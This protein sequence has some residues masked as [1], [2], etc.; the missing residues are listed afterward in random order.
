VALDVD[1]R[2]HESFVVSVGVIVGQVEIA[3]G[4][5]AL[6][7]HQIMGF[8]PGKIAAFEGENSGTGVVED[9]GDNKQRD[10]FFLEGPVGDSL[11]ISIQ[12]ELLFLVHGVESNHHE[13]K[14]SKEDGGAE[15]YETAEEI[16]RVQIICRRE[17]EKEE[18]EQGKVTQ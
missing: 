4:K 17:R 18:K 15:K 8:I 16:F 10:E 9:E 13:V 5:K 12:K 1:G 14:H 3:V 7:Y 2:P 11:E 6:G